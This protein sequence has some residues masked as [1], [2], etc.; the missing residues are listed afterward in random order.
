MRSPRA[1][2][3]ALILLLGVPLAAVAALAP[4]DGAGVIVH[5]A[6]GTC[7]LLLALSVRAFRAPAWTSPVACAAFVA[8]G[9]IFVLQAVTDLTHSASLTRLAY[10]ALGQRLLDAQEAGFGQRAHRPDR[11]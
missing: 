2:A 1:F 9:A 8:L 7:F 6:L 10:A 11:Q 5:L 3:A 4:G